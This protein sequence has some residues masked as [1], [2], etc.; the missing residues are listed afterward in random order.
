PDAQSCSELKGYSPD[1]LRIL[2]TAR[3]SGGWIRSGGCLQL[4]RMHGRNRPRTRIPL[5][6]VAEGS[7]A[8]VRPRSFRVRRLLL[9][10]SSRHPNSQLLSTYLWSLL[11]GWI[12]VL[13]PHE[14]S[15]RGALR[16]A[17]I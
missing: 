5:R 10:N 1:G 3:W 4:P 15:R 2:R 9:R 8:S 14:G 11:R 17:S 6:R 12:F 16:L 13:L 7:C